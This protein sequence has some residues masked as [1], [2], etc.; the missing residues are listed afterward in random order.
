MGGEIRSNVS[1]TQIMEYDLPR[2][3]D[4]GG[5]NAMVDMAAF[6]KITPVYREMRM[7]AS[8]RNVLLKMWRKIYTSTISGLPKLSTEEQTRLSWAKSIES[9]AGIPKLYKDFFEPFLAAGRVFPYTV[10]SP[11]YEGFIHRTTEKLICDFG[12]EIYVLERSGNTFEAKCYPLEGIS[13]VEIRAILLD[14]HVKIQG[15]TRDGIPASS[16]IKFNSVT[17]Y[18]FTPIVEKIRLNAVNAQDAVQNSEVAKFDHLLSVN[19]KF[20]NYARRSLLGDEKVIHIILQPEIRTRLLKVLGMTYYRTISPAHLSILTDREL[21]MIREEA[22]QSGD[23]RYGGIWNYIPLNKIVTLSL[24]ERGGNLLVLSIQLP[25]KERLEYLYQTSAK[26]DLDQFQEWFK[27]LT[28][29]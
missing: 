15:V 14:S 4:A 22:R 8:T 11:S 2:S 9:Y 10:L 27:K 5:R 19:Y 1:E 7:L 17:D 6:G 12:R 26:Q 28:A 18:L 20:R 25:E 24:G 3:N 21:I 29:R 23:D 13:Y 16:T